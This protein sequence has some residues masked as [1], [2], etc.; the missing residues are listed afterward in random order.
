LIKTNSLNIYGARYEF[1][2]VEIL[3]PIKYGYYFGRGAFSDFGC[4]NVNYTIF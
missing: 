1:G 4:S 2:A 3:Q